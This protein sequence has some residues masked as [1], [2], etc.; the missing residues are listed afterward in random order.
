MK[1]NHGEK[2]RGTTGQ[3][4]TTGPHRN[5]HPGRTGCVPRSCT[6]ESIDVWV[7]LKL[8]ISDVLGGETPVFVF[9]RCCINRQKASPTRQIDQS[10]RKPGAARRARYVE[11]GKRRVLRGVGCGG[12]GWTGTCGRPTG[13]PANEMRGGGGR[14]A[15][16]ILH[17]RESNPLIVANHRESLSGCGSR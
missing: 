17:L 7:R 4:R 14:G 3:G 6:P 15:V 2:D 13:R 11:V 16:Y 5:N 8:D 10:L 1:E 9:C 12:Y